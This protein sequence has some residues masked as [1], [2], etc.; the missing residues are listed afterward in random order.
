MPHGD[1]TIAA[2]SKNSAEISGELTIPKLFYQQAKRYGKDRV[3]M[4]EK[5]FGIWRPRR[6]LSSTV[7]PPNTSTF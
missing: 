7:I 3:A 2:T 6:M 1:K 4:R 5:E